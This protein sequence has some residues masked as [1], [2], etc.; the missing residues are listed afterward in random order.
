MNSVYL[1]QD[2]AFEKTVH[3]WFTLE[4]RWMQPSLCGPEIKY[5]L[6]DGIARKGIILCKPSEPLGTSFAWKTMF[7]GM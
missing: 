5:L 6:Q 3:F 1:W 4:N 2:L 7:C